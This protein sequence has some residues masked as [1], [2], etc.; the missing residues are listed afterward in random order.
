MHVIHNRAGVFKIFPHEILK[1][2]LKKLVSVMQPGPHRA[3]AAGSV[4]DPAVDP[5]HAAQP[6][7][8]G[9][10]EAEAGPSVPAAHPAHLRG[11][12]PGVC[13]GVCMV[14]YVCAVCAMCIHL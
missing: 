8:G 11:L 9:V 13:A 6:H 4:R 12:F 5:P 10:Q 7:S 14:C 1:T 3:L 2:S